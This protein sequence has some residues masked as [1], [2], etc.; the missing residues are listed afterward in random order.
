VSRADTLLKEASANPE[1]LTRWQVA[2]AAVKQAQAAVDEGARSRLLAL[3]G[4]IQAGL[5]AAQRDQ[6]LLDRLAEIRSAEVDDFRGLISDKAYTQSFSDAGIDLA[7]VKP[8]DAAAKIKARPPSVAQGMTAALDDWA[9]IRRRK[10]R[11]RTGAAQLSEVARIADPD[12]WRN[13]LRTAVDQ[14]DQAARLTALQ[15]L[16]KTAKFDELGPISLQLLGAALNENMG[17][18]QKAGDPALAESVLRKAQVRFPGDVWVNHELAKVLEGQ[19]RRDEAIRF[20]T[21]A[22]A[23][24]PEAGHQLAHALEK[25]GDLEEA[26]VVFRD[27][28]ALRPSNPEH[29]KCL[30]TM[31]AE[32]GRKPEAAAVL[33]Q[34]VAAY[35]ERIRIKPKD[36]DDH[37]DLALLLKFQGKLEESIAEFRAVQRLDPNHGFSW[38]PGGRMMVM[39]YQS[40]Q[41]TMMIMSGNPTEALLALHSQLGD[42]RRKEGKMD[43]AVS[44][45]EEAIRLQSRHE[46]GPF[47]GLFAAL[48]AQGKL[49]EAIAADRETIRREPGNAKVYFHLGGILQAKGDLAAALDVFR[50]GHELGARQSGWSYSS[51]SMLGNLGSKVGNT[52]KDQGKLDEAIAAYEETIQFTPAYE[53]GVFPGLVAALKAAGKL[54]QTIAADRET[55][56]REPGNAKVYFQLG[57]ILR[58][59]GDFAEAIALYRKGHELGSKQPGWSYP[60]EQWLRMAE[61][62]AARTERFNVLLR[63]G[64]AKDNKERLFTAIQCEQKKLYAAAARLTVEALE[65]DPKLGE[66]LPRRARHQAMGRSVLAGVGQG[67]DDPRPD[68]AARARLRTQARDLFQADI[69]IHSKKLASGNA[70]DRKVILNNLQ[71]WKECP[72]L[73]PVREPEASKGLPESERKEWEG[74]WAEVEA[75]FKRAQEQ[76]P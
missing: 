44:A 10:L 20:Y 36:A 68:D 58:A 6:A 4:Q 66:D 73:A 76:A 21:A 57:G 23:I 74:L 33:E 8:A 43:E 22:R 35:R 17:P 53:G 25:R 75:L 9:A 62:E 13:T 3:N 45:Y 5:D 52:L 32:K 47:T 38:N 41:P 2:L 67:E 12:A 29:I 34:A 56:R 50:K 40:G 51:T 11:N 42:V 46:A 49:D 37:F 63:G 24:R 16:A 61:Q 7:A 59:Q 54:D 64:P 65:H 70:D 69:A 19:N 1:D 60:S 26:I 39:E 30:Y 18:D 71:H 72:D 27:V 48:K 31:F 14:P 15:N 28:I 55:I